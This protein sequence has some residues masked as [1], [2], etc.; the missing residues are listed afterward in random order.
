MDRVCRLAALGAVMIES[1][2]ESNWEDGGVAARYVPLSAIFWT[3]LVGL[4]MAIFWDRIVTVIGVCAVTLAS[5]VS[6]Q[7]AVSVM[8]VSA[9][10]QDELAIAVRMG[11]GEGYG[12]FD[13]FAVPLMKTLTTTRSTG[14]SMPT[15]DCSA[16]RS[17]RGASSSAVLMSTAR[18]KAFS[19]RST[20]DSVRVKGWASSSERPIR[21]IVIAEE[22]GRVVGAASYGFSR[23]DV[24]LDAIGVSTADLGFIGVAHAGEPVYKHVR[25]GVRVRPCLPLGRLPG[26]R[27][28]V[29]F[30]GLS[31]PSGVHTPLVVRR[32]SATARPLHRSHLLTRRVPLAGCHVQLLREHFGARQRLVPLDDQAIPEGLELLHPARRGPQ[33]RPGPL[34]LGL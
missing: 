31:Q 27:A 8:A 32:P 24:D 15:A 23:P 25:P 3:A 6:G 11:L 17:R 10:Q 34:E 21:C 18:S 26:R 16:N 7:P 20:R 30:G 5:F 33:L 13:P 2:R 4:S 12:Y 14:T 22:S 29:T 19:L 1:S 28:G 9:L